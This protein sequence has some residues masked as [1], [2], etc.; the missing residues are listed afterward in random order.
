MI[1]FVIWPF[2][3]SVYVTFETLPAPAVPGLLYVTPPQ[4]TQYGTPM[5]E[6]SV[7]ATFLLV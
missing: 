1:W 7:V 2:N 3:V 6:I 5:T 4:Y